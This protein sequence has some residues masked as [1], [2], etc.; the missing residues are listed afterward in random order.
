MGDQH[1]D[2][3]HITYILKAENARLVVKAR[4]EFD[5]NLNEIDSLVF[6]AKNVNQIEVPIE[7]AE[8]CLKYI[9]LNEQ[10]EQIMKKLTTE[11]DGYLK[12]I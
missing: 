4:S 6:N 2:T 5:E 11:C 1:S 8:K 12:Q 7:F 9:E 3:N 10:R